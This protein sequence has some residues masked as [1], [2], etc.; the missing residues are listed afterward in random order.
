MQFICQ[1]FAANAYI[2]LFLVWASVHG[3]I[4]EML[5][6]QLTMGLPDLLREAGS[7]SQQPRQLFSR[8]NSIRLNMTP[9]TYASTEILDAS[10]YKLRQHHS[11]QLQ[12]WLV[13]RA[14]AGFKGHIKA[15]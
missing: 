12:A 9:F 4:C 10:K 13:D 15:G 5:T 7:N 1:P 11:M 3:A 14:E 2:L 6:T 8:S